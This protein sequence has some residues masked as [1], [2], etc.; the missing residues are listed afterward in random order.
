MKKILYLLL[1]LLMIG[2]FVFGQSYNN[3]GGKQNFLD[4]MKVSKYKDPTGNFALATDAN[5]RLQLVPRGGGGGGGTNNQ[6]ILLSGSVIWDSNFVFHN[7]LLSYQI[8]GRI[9]SAAYSTFS[10]PAADS[11][12]QRYSVIYADTSGNVGVI[13]GQA[14]N[15]ADIPQVN[16]QSQIL[17][18]IYY[19]PALATSPSSGFPPTE[20]TNTTV[21]KENVEWVLSGTAT[22]YSGSY[23]V[24]PYA[25][26]VSTRV[27]A[28][29]DGQWIEYT[30]GA[31][32]S[33]ASFSYLSME[34]RLGAVFD[35]STTLVVSFWLDGS[36]VSNT[37][38][39]AS[40][41]YGF[42]RTV[43]GSYQLI[44]FGLNNFT[45]FGG[46]LFNTIHIEFTGANA[47][48]FQV[49]NI[50]LQGGGTV[51]NN[52]GV[53]SYNARTGNVLPLQTDN[54]W[55][56]DSTALSTDS[57]TYYFYNNGVLKSTLPTLKRVIV[58]TSPLFINPGT[59]NEPDTIGSSGGSGGSSQWRDTT[60]GIYYSLGNVGIG[61]IN[62]AQALA[63]KG[64]AGA[65]TQIASHIS[66]TG[67][68]DFADFAYFNNAGSVVGAFRANSATN[69]AYGGINSINFINV[70]PAPLTFATDNTVRLWVSSTGGVAIGAAAP[71]ASAI[72]DVPST[73]QGALL[74]RMTAAQRIAISS[75]ATGLIA[76]DTDSTRYMV[77]QG[78]AWKGLKYT[79][80]G[81]GSGG[82][83][84]SNF[85]YNEEFTGSTS[86]T[87]T[88]ANTPVT[89]KLEVFKNGVKLTNSEFSL[90][91]A[92]VTLTSTRFT[93]DI[94]SNN[95][96]K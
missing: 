91:T 51:I 84:S 79:D 53:L 81:G 39:L 23:P 76:Y 93:S 9:F 57:L 41:S 58:A 87:Y 71:A 63:V 74:P 85:V 42:T 19:V 80:E 6:T 35:A 34:L 67:A 4:S 16:P 28:V 95:Y 62:P 27:P 66:G 75:P 68:S 73:T 20:I 40:G 7:T 90:S 55:D 82:L 24:N 64:T 5:G 50:V 37:I 60:S 52:S 54:Q 31:E 30:N 96:I 86:L 43:A 3:I 89:G 10:I 49:D 72:L 36:P 94:I 22:G 18:A 26:L 17:L 2:S 8:L 59:G 32:V 61:T 69:T 33:A 78:S 70:L 14:L 1:P 44:A 12:S 65:G 45:F 77:Y 46:A 29:I 92:T 48:G 11:F 15:P 38:T 25:G 83:A 56:F 13:N 88:L 21:Y 47:S